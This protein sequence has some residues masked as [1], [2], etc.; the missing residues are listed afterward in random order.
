MKDLSG[1]LF[2]LRKLNFCFKIPQI[3]ALLVGSIV[4]A[5]P[6]HQSQSLLS[7]PHDGLQLEP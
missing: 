7:E 6:D 5:K 3:L 4:K 2:Y 1:K